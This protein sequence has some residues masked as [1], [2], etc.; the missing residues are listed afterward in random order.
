MESSESSQ[1]AV[2]SGSGTKHW[3]NSVFHLLYSKIRFVCESNGKIGRKKLIFI[4]VLPASICHLD[5]IYTLIKDKCFPWFWAGS[6][7]VPAHHCQLSS[8][9]NPGHLSQSVEWNVIWVRTFFKAIKHCRK[10]LR[11]ILYIK[12]RS[13]FRLI[14][15]RLIPRLIPH[16]PF[17][18]EIVDRLILNKM[19]RRRSFNTWKKFMAILWVWTWLTWNIIP[20]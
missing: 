10:H 9:Q 16:C 11:L 1:R 7:N 18:T 17:A 14:P 13:S 20:Y 5:L 8:D 2:H 12:Q 15:L 4:A 3:P 19:G 6:V